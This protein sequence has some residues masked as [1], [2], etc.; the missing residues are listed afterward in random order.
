MTDDLGDRTSIVE[1]YRSGSGAGCDRGPCLVEVEELTIQAGALVQVAARNLDS[2]RGGHAAHLE[3]VEAGGADQPFDRR[4]R[5]V[6]IGGVEEHC[7]TRLAVRGAC[8]RVGTE[9]AERLHVVRT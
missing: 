3:R 4:R 2:S 5:S 1:S 6:V 7:A 9:R 8:E